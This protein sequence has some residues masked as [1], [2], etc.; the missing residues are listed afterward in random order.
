MTSP[1]SKSATPLLLGSIPKTAAEPIAW[2]N[3]TKDDGRVFYTSM[4]H[5]DDFNDADFERL[6]LNALHWVARKTPKN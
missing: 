4:G 5:P 1:L 2:I 3:Q 6:M